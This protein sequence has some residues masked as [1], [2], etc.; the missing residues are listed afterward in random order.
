MVLAAAPAWMSAE[1]E[2][3]LALDFDVLVPAWLPAPFS[4]QPRASTT[5]GYYELYWLITGGAPTFLQITGSVGGDIPD[6]S[7]Y[8]R[9]NELTVNA[10]VGGVPAY[11][12]LTPIYDNV[13]WEV[14]NV[15]YTVSS[16]GLTDTDSLAL[17][18]ALV[19]LE[20]APPPP[21]E[22]E[23]EPA[24]ISALETVTSGTTLT[25][26]VS[27]GNGATLNA[28]G[29]TFV[30]TGTST[31]TD[32]DNATV[33][34]TAPDVVSEES[35]TFSLTN[36]SAGDW[37]AG[38]ATIVIPP[39]APSLSLSCL[40]EVSPGEQV[41]VTAGGAGSVVVEASHGFWPEADP[42][43]D[44]DAGAGDSRLS[45][46]IGGS[47]SVALL[48]QA[49]ETTEPVSA[50]I[51]LSGMSGI[52]TASCVVAVTP[53]EEPNPTDPGPEAPASISTPATSS[54]AVI[55]AETPSQSRSD[56]DG[57]A[58][59]TATPAM[60]NSMN[61]QV[62]RR[63]RPGRDTS[64]SATTPRATSTLRLPESDG[65]GGAGHPSYVGAPSGVGSGSPLVAPTSAPLPPAP[66]PVLSGV[67]RSSPENITADASTPPTLTPVP[68]DTASRDMDTVEAM[69]GPEGGMLSHPAGAVLT[70]P[71]GVFPS[72]S[73]VSLRPV[74]D[75][76]LSDSH[77][78]ALVPGTGYDIKVY[79]VDGQAITRLAR[80]VTL[81]LAL[82]SG[83]DP[84][85]ATVY[86]V[87]SNALEAMESVSDDEAMIHASLTHFSRFAAGTAREEP[88]LPGWILPWLVIAGSAV[89]ILAASAM[90]GSLQRRRA[91]I[92]RRSG[93]QRVR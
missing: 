65:T 66:R 59:S 20:Q 30:D 86:S 63:N 67:T 23:P 64:A 58:T 42:N 41:V 91:R 60:G 12:D 54:A 61:Q 9:N 5:S 21:P 11:R 57:S 80:A 89:V 46:D 83:L 25:I 53:L 55:T 3:L 76:A 8:D 38:A 16:Q 31:Y 39:A 81:G 43:I 77:D 15:V 18:N 75:S 62:P 47:G 79:A 36:G 48:W 29:G 40:P 17:A 70:V 14:D 7:W 74:P 71:A 50:T 92:T 68:A 84:Q 45:G 82:P 56:S 4:D 13:Y 6:F 19:L 85:Q 24:T 27:N 69:I 44:F 51:T 87:E 2:S 72:P 78:V 93:H 10:D 32:L 26:T 90:A 33:I 73:R 34:W 35:V 52:T 1:T 37:I 28:S 49:P 88:V 22:P